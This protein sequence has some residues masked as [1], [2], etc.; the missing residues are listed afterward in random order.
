MGLDF[1][2]FECYGT[3]SIKIKVVLLH[4]VFQVKLKREIKGGRGI[5]NKRDL[6][7][8]VPS[9]LILLVMALKFESE[10]YDF[11]LGQW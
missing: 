7:S 5:R 6:L 11:V 9:S 10:I 1:E 2:A 8:V 3:S 4:P